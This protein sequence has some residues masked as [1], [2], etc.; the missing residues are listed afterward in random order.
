MTGG[1]RIPPLIEDSSLPDEE[2][3][4]L[5]RARALIPRLAARA[6]AATAAR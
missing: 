2:R 3:V 1:G 4:L 6:P 5:E